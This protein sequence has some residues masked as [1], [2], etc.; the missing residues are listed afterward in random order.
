MFIMFFVAKSS[1][2][3]NNSY[4]L[5]SA[6]HLFGLNWQLQQT[7]NDTFENGK[8]NSDTMPTNTVQLPSGD[9]GKGKNYVSFVFHVA[10]L[11]I[12]LFLPMLHPISY[13]SEKRF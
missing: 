13:G 4:S 8:V 10:S 7:E 11:S 3:L 6:M 12:N 9:N 2:P 5:P 1:R